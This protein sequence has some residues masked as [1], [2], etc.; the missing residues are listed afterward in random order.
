ME[1]ERK[2]VII[3][4]AVVL[5]LVILLASG[6]MIFKNRA[7]IEQLTLQN[8]NLSTTIE[9]RDSLVNEM[10]N[11]FD[12]IEQ[13][14]TFVRNKRNQ[15]ISVPQEGGNSSKEILVDDIKLMN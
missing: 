3:S 1:T 13:N 15:M 5:F 7:Q 8:E 10:T 2:S 12:E 4:I 9:V 11:T 14:L 6:L